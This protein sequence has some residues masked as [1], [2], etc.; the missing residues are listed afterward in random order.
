MNRFLKGAMILTLAGIIVKCCGAI[1]KVLLARILGGEGIG[2]YQMAYPVYQI[3]VGLA[4]A[5]LPIAISIM[6]AEKL[7]NQDMKGAKRVLHSSLVTLAALGVIFSGILYLLSSY[8]IRWGIVVDERAY[9]ALEALSPAILVVTLLS[10]LRGYFQGFQNMM[11]TGVSQICEQIIR[12]TAMVGLAIWLLPKGLGYGAAGATLATFPAAFVGLCVLLVFYVRQGRLRRDLLAAQNTLIALEGYASILKRL[13]ILAIP[14]SIA[15]IMMPIVTGVDLLIV[16]HRLVESGYSISQATASFGYLTGMATSLVNLPVILTTSLAASLVPAVSEAFTMKD[17]QR[18]RN[19]TNTAMKIAN[20]ITIPAFVGLCVLA[21]PVSLLLYATP[22]AGAP[23]AVMSLSVF[24]LGIQQVTTGVLQGL[25][26]T[27]IPMINLA[28]GLGIK[29]ILDWYLTIIP[30]LGVNGAAWA[31]NVDFGIA[32]ILNVYFVY[33]YVGYTIRWGELA[34]IAFSALAM[35]GAVTVLFY[36]V[37]G[38]VGNTLATMVAII[39][40]VVIYVIALFVTRAMTKSDLQAFPIIG[41]R[42]R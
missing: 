38:T 3:V 33:R 31:T 16:P 23:I 25:G 14:V 29:I 15:N 8:L 5:G 24:L 20:V 6:I 35:G 34:K 2:I 30:S 40:A 7:A 1:G 4:T 42:F 26:R 41:K 17:I 28:I 36:F 37:V 19:R 39:G 21:T 9:Y 22:N 32:A 10:C 27:S 18:I 13:F 12:I 11:P